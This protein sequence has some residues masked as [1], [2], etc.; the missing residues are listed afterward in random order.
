MRET[1][2]TRHPYGHTVIGY[3][4][5]VRAMPQGYAYSQEF[6]DRYY[7]PENVVVVMAG[8]FDSAAAKALIRKYYG[9]WAAASQRGRPSPPNRRRPSRDA[10]TVTYPGRTLPIVSIHHRAPAWNARPTARRWRSRCSGGPRSAPNSPLY[11]RLVLQERRA[12][13]LRQSFDLRAIRIWSP[14]RPW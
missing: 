5:D 6:Y 7:R 13:T 10:A 4:A 1:A 8:D 11:R 9:G 12:Q 14:C 2:F 3:E